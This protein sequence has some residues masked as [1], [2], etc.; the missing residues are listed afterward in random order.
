MG[1]SL[2]EQFR[3][4]L[5]VIAN[6]FAASGDLWGPGNYFIIRTISIFLVKIFYKNGQNF[7]YFWLLL[8]GQDQLI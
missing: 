1:E 7:L 5:T 2:N 3:V 8:F 4:S 6:R